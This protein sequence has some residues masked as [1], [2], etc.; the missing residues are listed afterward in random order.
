M[1]TSIRTRTIMPAILTDAELGRLDTQ[2]GH[3]K[4]LR[5]RHGVWSSIGISPRR[6]RVYG[7]LGYDPIARG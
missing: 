4:A 2:A 3:L 1:I 7:L 5:V 6:E